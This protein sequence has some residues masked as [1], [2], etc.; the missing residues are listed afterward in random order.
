MLVQLAV[1]AKPVPN[2]SFFFFK[3]TYWFNLTPDWLSDWIIHGLSVFIKTTGNLGSECFNL[4]L[5]QP[6]ISWFI[7]IQCLHIHI[8]L[9]PIQQFTRNW[10]GGTSKNATVNTREG[11]QKWVGRVGGGGWGARF[12]AEQLSFHREMQTPESLPQ[13]LKEAHPN[14]WY[15]LVL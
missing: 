15:Q 14:R 9:L 11:L 1:T 12:R 3:H 10:T 6:L 13:W 5:S 8:F 4:P 7:H 2:L